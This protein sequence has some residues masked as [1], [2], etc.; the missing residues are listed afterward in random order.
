MR[1]CGLGMDQ[2]FRLAEP[3]DAWSPQAMGETARVFTGFLG[4]PDHT[5]IQYA[6]KLMRSEQRHNAPLLFGEEALILRA[7]QDVP[8]VSRLIELGFIRLN[9]GVTLPED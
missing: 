3:L 7:L 1:T 8:G 4:K 9:E 5:L 2:E 6:V